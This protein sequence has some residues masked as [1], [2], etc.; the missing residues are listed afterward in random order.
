LLDFIHI[1]CDSL[2]KFNSAN[3]TRG[4]SYKPNAIPRA[5]STNVINFFLIESLLPELVHLL[6]LIILAT[7]Q[8]FQ[9]VSLSRVN[10]NATAKQATA[11][12]CI[13]NKQIKMRSLE[14]NNLTPP[15]WNASVTILFDAKTTHH[16]MACCSSNN[17]HLF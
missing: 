10:L 8:K 17:I 9:S 12:R 15:N 6:P 11:E 5:A 14:K 1:D 4:H 16:L 13:G 3:I 2:F 7:I